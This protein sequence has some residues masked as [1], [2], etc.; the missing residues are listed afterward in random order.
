MISS[1]HPVPLEMDE[2]SVRG[3]ECDMVRRRVWDV[4]IIVRCVVKI[5]GISC[6]LS[7]LLV[8]R[9]LRIPAISYMYTEHPNCPIRSPYS[10]TFQIKKN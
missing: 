5:F 3:V 4:K 8:P 6:N 2:M 10:Y 7:R 9:D 1:G